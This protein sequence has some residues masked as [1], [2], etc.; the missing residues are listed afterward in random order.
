VYNEEAEFY[1]TW[2]AQL[3]GQLSDWKVEY[4]PASS[5]EVMGPP[6][7][8][9][10]AEVPHPHDGPG[11]WGP[12]GENF[13][14]FSKE[15]Q[16]FITGHPISEAYWVNGKKFDGFVNGALIDAKGDYGQFLLPNGQWE[17]FFPGDS[18]F[19]DLAAAQSGAAA[20]IPIYWVFA[21]Q[22]V[23]DY[24]AALLRVAKYYNITC[25]WK[26]MG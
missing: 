7:T 19:L 12:S 17:S 9:P 6:G 20:S 5:A 3:E 8:L 24:V 25:V 13:G 21:Q 1:N 4:T 18:H 10:A 15:Y 11:H 2:K 22:N 23:A 16:E 26:P 14:G